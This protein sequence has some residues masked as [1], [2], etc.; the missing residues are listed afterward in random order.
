M[1]NGYFGGGVF[2]RLN[3]W[4]HQPG[5]DF[6]NKHRDTPIGFSSN[7]KEELEMEL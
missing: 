1:I 2:D 4:K 3:A 6:P 7:D 5:F